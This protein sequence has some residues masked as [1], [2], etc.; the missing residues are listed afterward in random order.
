MDQATRS[1]VESIYFETVKETLDRG[2]GNL[3]AHKEAITAAA[4]LLA[5]M[6]N[7][8]DDAAKRAVVALSL[9]PDQSED[10]E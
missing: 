1:L 3:S 2:G 8:E 9:R 4:M 7:I 5:A 6:S 10:K